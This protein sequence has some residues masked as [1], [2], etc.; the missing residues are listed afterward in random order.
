[1]MSPILFNRG[2]GGIVTT[3][4]TE[5]RTWFKSEERKLI[6]YNEKEKS[7]FSS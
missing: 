3:M 7:S 6:E 4:A 1:M 2:G 5:T